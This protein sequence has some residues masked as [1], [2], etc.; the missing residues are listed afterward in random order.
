[1]TINDNK[2]NLPFITQST[3]FVVLAYCFGGLLLLFIGKSCDQYTHSIATP[4][5]PF[6]HYSTTQEVVQ[7]NGMNPS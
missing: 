4:Q 1:M 7:A 6:L 3:T 2:I 5:Y